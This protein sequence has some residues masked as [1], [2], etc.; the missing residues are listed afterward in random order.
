MQSHNIF[1]II[2]ISLGVPLLCLATWTRHKGS[3][4]TTGIGRGWWNT[5]DVW[6][7]I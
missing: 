6:R 1:A 3:P 4:V 5:A 2:R 7:Y